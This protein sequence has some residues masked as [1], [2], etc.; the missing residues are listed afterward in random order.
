MK[1]IT[2]ALLFSLAGYSVARAE[3]KAPLMIIVNPDNPIKEISAQE[4]SDFYLKKSRYWQ[5]GSKIR[6]FDQASNSNLKSWFLQKI[7]KKTPRELDL[8][9]IGEKNF[10]GQGAPVVAPSDDM[11]ISSVASLPGAIG[12]I[13]ATD[14]DLTGV[15]K[16]ILKGFE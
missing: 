14:T 5:D 9:W 2:L 7:L 6:F 15:K 16:L 10:N 13:S 8:F 4:V 12:Y 3:D 11:V 1:I